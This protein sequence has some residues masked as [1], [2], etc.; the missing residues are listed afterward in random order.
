MARD[1]TVRK[2]LILG[3]LGLLIAADTALIAYSWH[4]D[5]ASRT[6]QQIF[7]EESQQ[8]K[9]LKADV[10]R[11]QKIR[12]DI[13]AIQRDCDRFEG[14]LPPA[15]SGYSTLVGDLEGIARKAGVKIAGVNFHEKQ[16]ADK[17]FVQ[18][19]LDT[20]IEGD[21][22]GVVRFVNGVQK[23]Q[24]LYI[25]N[26]LTLGT[27]SQNVGGTLRVNLHL[28]TYFRAAV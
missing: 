6:P 15:A 22:P 26:D 12:K 18:V 24:G 9:L 2:R 16:L 21:Y 25:V 1:F 3:A 10:E 7:A 28:Q 4:A 14:S 19:I 11:A 27:S 20:T 17:P 13:P 8:L 5:S 23:A